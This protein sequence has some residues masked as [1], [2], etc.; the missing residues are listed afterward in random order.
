MEGIAQWSV[1]A[2]GHGAFGEAQ[3][4]AAQRGE[5]GHVPVRVLGEGVPGEDVLDQSHV[6]AFLGGEGPAAEAEVHGP[7]PPHQPGEHHRGEGGKDAQLDLGLSELG[8][9]ACENHVAGQRDFEAPA[10]GGSVQ[11]GHHGEFQGEEAIQGSVEHADHLADAVLGVLRHVHARAEGLARTRHHQHGGVGV[12]V[13]LGGSLVQLPEHGDVQ[14][15]EGRTV[16][17]QP[18]Q[19]AVPFQPEMS[20]GP[21]PIVHDPAPDSSFPHTPQ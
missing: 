21:A 17:D 2:C 6:L 18:P 13:D 1:G 9:R 4:R 15:V 20:K 11:H 7:C 12:R 8:A 16:Q 10:Q 3:H 5:G 14:D 19:T